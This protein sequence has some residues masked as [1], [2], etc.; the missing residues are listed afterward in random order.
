MRLDA[1]LTGNWLRF[2]HHE[3]TGCQQDLWS[4]VSWKH[5][6][7]RR[8]ANFLANLWLSPTITL[9]Q[10][11]FH[12][13]VA[14]AEVVDGESCC[15]IRWRVASCW[16]AVAF[17]L[18]KEIWIVVDVGET[19]PAGLTESVDCTILGNSGNEFFYVVFFT[20]EDDAD[21]ISL[22]YLTKKPADNTDINTTKNNWRGRLLENTNKFTDW[23]VSILQKLWVFNSS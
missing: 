22:I 12:R 10:P 17:Y 11:I 15:I 21:D 3:R 23:G 7:R 6:T 18:S 5:L 14:I 20:V 4:T 9:V 19:T 8:V 2:C 13:S 16:I 1:A